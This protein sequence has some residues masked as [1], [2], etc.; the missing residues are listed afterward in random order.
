MSPTTIIEG[1]MPLKDLRR[2]NSRDGFTLI[3][4]LV[5]V[6]ILA[7]SL[8]VL[9]GIFSSGLKS[10]RMA[11]EYNI[12]VAQADN[13]LSDILLMSQSIEPGN[14][15]GVFEN[16]SRWTA[17]ISPWDG[18][19]EIPWDSRDGKGLF[20]IA[21]TITWMTGEQEKNYTLQTITHK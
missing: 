1:I 8:S 6:V 14:E 15:S 16:K 11:Q 13:V 10:K 3:E 9:M 17:E 12:A 19:G 2:F 7:M 20:K 21:V 4:V 5:S 18:H